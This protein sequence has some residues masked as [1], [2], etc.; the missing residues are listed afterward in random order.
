MHRCCGDANR[1]RH[2]TVVGI[3]VPPARV[4]KITFPV[5]KADGFNRRVFVDDVLSFNSWRGLEEHRP[6][7]SINRLKR[8]VYDASSEFRHKMNNAP[9]NRAGENW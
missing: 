5:Q 7:G 6:L 1:G 8:K 2:R 3:G 9:R 4:A